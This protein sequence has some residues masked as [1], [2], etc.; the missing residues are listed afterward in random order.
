MRE[1]DGFA[2]DHP[3][4]DKSNDFPKGGG[5]SGHGARHCNN[6]PEDY[7]AEGAMTSPKG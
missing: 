1:H 2:E 6:I 5:T 7:Q 4:V 3:W